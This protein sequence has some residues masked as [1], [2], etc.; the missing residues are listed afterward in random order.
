MWLLFVS[1][2]IYSSRSN[3]SIIEAYKT[4]AV[5]PAEG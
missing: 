4:L 5:S 1:F 3:N 2:S